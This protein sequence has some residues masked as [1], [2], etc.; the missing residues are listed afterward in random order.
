MYT[1]KYVLVK[2]RK[3]HPYRRNSDKNALQNLLADIKYD[4]MKKAQITLSPLEDELDQRYDKRHV[5]LNPNI[6]Y[7]HE[8]VRK[9][10]MKLEKSIKNHLMN[11]GKYGRLVRRKV[12]VRKYRDFI[13]Q[14]NQH[15]ISQ[16][17]SQED[18]PPQL[19]N[20][21]QQPFSNTTIRNLGEKRCK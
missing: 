20:K 3:A 2:R 13:R 12:K 4:D 19:K 16:D 1:F 21:T 10:S 14:K 6:S 7:E 9:S 17:E 15:I 18:I 5:Q 8:N 11:S